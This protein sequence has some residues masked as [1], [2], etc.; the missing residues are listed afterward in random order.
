[1]TFAR[2]LGLT[3]EVVSALQIADARRRQDLEGVVQ[4]KHAHV[5]NI[6]NVQAVLRKAIEL[7]N[8]SSSEKTINWRKTGLNHATSLALF[9]PVPARLSDT[10]L[11]WGEGISHCEAGYTIDIKTINT[12][13]RVSSVLPAFL[14]PFLDAILLEG[15][16]D[17]RLTIRRNDAIANKRPLFTKAQDSFSITRR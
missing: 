5:A 11:S 15:L 2:H 14:N 10:E 3:K 8:A 17:R 13:Q 9:V 1:V 7:L 16:G 6:G 4:N 12:G